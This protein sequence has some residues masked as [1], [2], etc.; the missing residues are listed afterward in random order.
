[1][2]LNAGV[3]NVQVID[4]NGCLASNSILLEE[5][6]VL[7]ASLTQQTDLVCATQCTGAISYSSTGGVGNYTFE[8]VSNGSSG[9]ASGFLT[10]L[11]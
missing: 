7:Q 5:P 3:L 9:M 4:E 2:N 8:L 10:N 1:M 11:C 6:A